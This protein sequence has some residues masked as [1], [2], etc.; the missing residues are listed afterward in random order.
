V[1]VHVVALPG[2]V[3]P[4]AQRY[5]P[6]AAA[7]D[8]DVRLHLKDLEV[9]SGEEPPP[10]YSIEMEVEAL[11]K[12]ADSLGLKRFNL[13]AYSGGG[14]VSLAFA[15]AH[16]DRLLSLALFEPA[17]VPGTLTPQ[18]SELREQLRAELEGKSG[19]D[20]MRA[21][22]AL[23]I[24]EGVELPP[25]PGGPPPPF[26]RN[27]P[28]GI[29]AMMAAFGSHAFERDSLRRCR[30]PVFYAYGDLTAVHQEV[31]V[32]ILSQLLPDIHVRRFDGIHHFVPPD[33]IYTPAHLQ[34]LRELWA[35]AK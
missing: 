25:P 24:K 27:R 9:Y 6:I 3:M 17:G 28:T 13:L 23:Q 22:M 32:G 15:G 8:G 2:S 31:W 16:P 30:C 1:T 34:V 7:L 26:M 19:P 11:R 14:F 33:Q 18:E 21:F 4:A 29:N 20:F 5:Q 10:G 12:F 35:G